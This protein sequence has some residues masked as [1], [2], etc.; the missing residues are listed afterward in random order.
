MPFKECGGPEYYETD[1]QIVKTKFELAGYP[2][3]AIVF[4]NLRGDGKRSTRP[5]SRDDKNVTF[6]NG[7]SEQM[8][9][10]FLEGGEFDTPYSA[11]LKTLGTNY[12]ILKVI[13]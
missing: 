6:I 8:L 10:T 4:W 7:F 12:D 1:Y 3:P 13:D 11:M 9:K 2:L 5:V